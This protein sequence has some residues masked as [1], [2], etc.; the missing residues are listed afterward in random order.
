MT[1]PERYRHAKWLL[2]VVAALFLFLGTRGL[3]EPDEGRY[4][5]IAREMA[6]TGE[7]LVPHLNGFEHFQKPPLLYWLTA[8]S[9]RVLG[10]NEWAA[11]LPSALAALGVV[12]LTH[13]IA[14]RLFDRATAVAAVLV[15]VSSFEFF[16]LGRL[17]TPDMLLTFWVTAAIAALVSGRRWLFF[18][19]MGFGFLTK[20]PMALVVPVSAAFGWQMFPRPDGEKLKL[21]WGRGMALTLGV[22]LSWFVLLSVRNG[23]LLDYFWRYELV[24]RFTSSA[25]GRSKPFW[26]FAPVL[27]VGFLPW[28][29]F[30]PAQAKE[31]WTRWKKSEW[32]N[33]DGLLCCWIILP[34]IILS[35]SGSK[36]PTYILPLFPALSMLAAR[37][38]RVQ[39]LQWQIAPAAICCW[40]AAAAVLPIFNDRLQQQAS[41]RT[42]AAVLERQ[43]DAKGADVFACEVRA[44]GF[45][46]YLG[47]LVSTTRD[48]ADIV[49]PVS[50]SQQAR[51]FDSPAALEQAF[52]GHERAYGIVR[53]ERFEK[54]FDAS[55]WSV[56]AQAGDFLLISN[57]AVAHISLATPPPDR[58]PRECPL[59]HNSGGPPQ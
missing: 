19:C 31:L 55:R 23:A 17:L 58:G 7:W 35:L 46:F 2:F 1:E 18:I 27:V 34:L 10:A 53:T 52:L 16:A 24:E 20:G 40:V 49:L 4:A 25:H 44:H 50:P 48:Q 30:L 9:I 47:R 32:M 43:P 37:N 5:E 29:F 26:Y 21:P 41:V 3:N 45:A 42:L 51:L 22:G 38:L 11:R 39:A 8:A 28:I 59:L 12:L 6:V 54:T 56:L 14:R 57:Q 33:T 15:V 13:G 36:L